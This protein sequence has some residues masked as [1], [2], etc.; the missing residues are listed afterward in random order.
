MNYRFASVCR[1][2]A[3]NWD[4]LWFQHVVGQTVFDD[5]GLWNYYADVAL[6]A[7]K[8]ILDDVFL[9]LYLYSAITCCN[10]CHQLLCMHRRGCSTEG[11]P[12]SEKTPGGGFSVNVWRVSSWKPHQVLSGSTGGSS[13]QVILQVITDCEC[14]S[15]HSDHNLSM[16]SDIIWQSLCMDHGLNSR[17][18]CNH[19]SDQ[20]VMWHLDLTELWWAIPPAPIFDS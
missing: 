4:W 16:S 12:C 14:H 20:F 10:C 2:P 1:F 18:L 17:F 3:E 7:L 8:W 13:R 6:N 11:I 5:N 9:F 15:S 19:G